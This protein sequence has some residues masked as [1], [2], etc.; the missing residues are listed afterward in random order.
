MNHKKMYVG[1]AFD[2]RLGCAVV[3]ETMHKLKRTRH[4]NTVFAVGTVQE[5]IGLRGAGTAAFGVNPDVAIAIDVGPAKDTPG[6]KG[7]HVEKLGAGVAIFVFDAGL[8]PNV[9]L[10]KLVIDTAEKHKIPYCLTTMHRGA[11]DA[12][13]IQI[14]R[15]GVPSICIAAIT[16]YIHAHTSVIYRDDYL[17]CIKLLTEVVKSLDMKTVRGLTQS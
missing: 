13:K 1:K 3:I 14:V 12:G 16:R 7:D 10:K 6:I 11:T 9:K 15:Q 2:D 8:I 5:E 17:N 4:P